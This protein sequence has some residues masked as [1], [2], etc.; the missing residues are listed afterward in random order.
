M[1][2]WESLSNKISIRDLDLD[3]VTEKVTQFRHFSITLSVV[4]GSAGFVWT[5]PGAVV[6]VVKYFR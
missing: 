4:T 3:L 6:V 2:R 5:V 1:L